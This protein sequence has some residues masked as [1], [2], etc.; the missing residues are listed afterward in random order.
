MPERYALTPKQL[1]VLRALGERIVEASATEV[2]VSALLSPTDVR[3][4]LATLEEQQLVTSW[5]PVSGRAGERLFAL[6]EEG[7]GVIHALPDSDSIPAAGTIM[8][9]PRALP[10]FLKWMS[11]KSPTFVQ[12]AP[13]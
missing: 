13:E 5:I 10:G 2:A 7:Q 8:R 4:T 6:T 1:H 9:I 12:V 3:T 11:R